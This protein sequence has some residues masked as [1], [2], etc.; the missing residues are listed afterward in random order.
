MLLSRK[1]I[2]RRIKSKN[3]GN[4]YEKIKKEVTFEEYVLVI[5]IIDEEKDKQDLWYQEND[6]IQF[7]KQYNKYIDAT[8]QRTL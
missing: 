1:Q 7:I 5:E 4:K 3:N 2:W 6:Y 8:T